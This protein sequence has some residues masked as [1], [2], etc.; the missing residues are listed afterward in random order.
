MIFT[1]HISGIWILCFLCVGSQKLGF[2]YDLMEFYMEKLKISLVFFFFLQGSVV[3]PAAG[4]LGSLFV[5]HHDDK[6]F[7]I[8]SNNFTK[9]HSCVAATKN[10]FLRKVC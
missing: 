7:G 6:H 9:N 8:Q 1:F 10:G 5:Y 2:N 3:G 4:H